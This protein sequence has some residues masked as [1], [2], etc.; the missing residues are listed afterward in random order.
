MKNQNTAEEEEV[1]SAKKNARYSKLD[2]SFG[3]VY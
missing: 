2:L 3:F 1:E